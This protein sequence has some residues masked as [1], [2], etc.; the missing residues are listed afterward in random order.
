MLL[1]P[2]PI[3]ALR[4]ARFREENGELDRVK[5][6]YIRTTYDRVIKPEQQEA[7]I[8]EWLPEIVYEMDTD[9]SP[10][11]SNPSLLFGLLV[12]AAAAA[13]ASSTAACN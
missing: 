1:R 5:R 6:V 11:F 3:L 10:F 4:T 2:G 12:K 8:R 13:A 9:H 7:M